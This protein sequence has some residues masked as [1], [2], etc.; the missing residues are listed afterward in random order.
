MVVFGDS[1]LIGADTSS[2]GI[3][4]Q[5]FNSDGTKSGAEFQVNTIVIGP[6]YEPEIAA[7]NDGRF[8][9]VY[10]GQS[11]DDFSGTAV[12][13]QV[14]NADGTK[15]GAEFMVNTTTTDGQSS[16]VVTV[17]SD[18]RFVVSFSDFSL[19]P[20]DSSSSAVRGQIFDPRIAGIDIGGTANNDELVGSA[21]ADVIK[22]N[23]GNDVIFGG[24]D[25]DRIEG[26]SGK[27]KLF[28]EEGMDK[29]YG[30]G[31]KDIL[32]GGEGNDKLFGQ[33]GKDK[34]SGGK[35]NDKLTGN[36]GK[37]V[38]V[39]KKKDGKDTIND[40]TNGKDK[41]DLK[42]F[43]FAN[44]GAALAK[45]YEIGSGSNDKLGFKYKGTEI[46]IKGID[47]GDLNGA[48]III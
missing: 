36:S 6:Q 8:V 48:D 17:L 4:G 3:R 26:N 47:L 40:F 39:F 28:G 12:M 23:A 32:K 33:G 19:S 18:G 21:F 2:G 34:I 27:D 42:A 25:D 16:A 9:V 30:G 14:F 37:D 11:L 45:F 29:L 35:G 5:V 44:K 31:D 7:L 10:T 38:F 22:G 1:S 15:S 41:I 13:A 24:L 20:D 46:I 43:N